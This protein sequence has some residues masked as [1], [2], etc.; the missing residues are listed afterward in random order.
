MEENQTTGRL[1]KDA[2]KKLTNTPTVH[3]T[4]EHFQGSLTWGIKKVKKK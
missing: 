3:I 1:S 4:V 2:P